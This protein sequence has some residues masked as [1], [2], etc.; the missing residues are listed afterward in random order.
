MTSVETKSPDEIR[1]LR[2]L[3]PEMR[4]RDFARVHSISEAELVAAQVGSTAIRLNVDLD[5]LLNGLTAV[6]E[7]MALTRNESAVHEKIGPYEKIV[8]GPRASLVLGAQID[9]RIFPSRWAFGFAVKK[10]AEDGAVKRSLQFF[11]AQGD[12]VHKVH[13]RPATNE[14]AW[15]ILVA[16]LRH[17]EQLD[18]VVTVPAV[19]EVLGEP[20]DAAALREGWSAMTDTHQ[21]FGLLK[22][23]N[24]PRLDAL[25]LAGEDFAWQLD[26][27]AVQGL[28]DSV[29]GTDLPIMAFIG[30]QGCIQIHAGPITNIKPMGP[31]LNILDETFHMHLR[32]DQVVSA[33]GVRK[34]TSDGHITSVELYDANRELIMQFFG[35]REEGHGEREGWR[36]V[37]QNLPV[38][39]KSNAA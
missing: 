22:K 20:S 16:N 33:W 12:A 34:P 25:E 9:L 35:Q 17:E 39:S 5:I 6:G 14:E 32:L 8:L 1:Q 4:E 28:F 36:N 31:W 24:L 10:T 15:N 21:F 3:H 30:N 27:A 37:V 18:S 29:A 13:A 19:P 7:V 26:H 23:H 2:A 38:Y 11:D